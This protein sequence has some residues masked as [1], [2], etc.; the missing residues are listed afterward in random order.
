MCS[1]ISDTPSDSEFCCTTTSTLQRAD[2]CS[3]QII[4]AADSLQQAANCCSN[5]VQIT[6]LKQKQ[7][8]HLEHTYTS[9]QN[10]ACKYR[11]RC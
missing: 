2:H 10:T 11:S 4:A 8:A 9:E 6:N 5:A 3:K 1:K 7:K